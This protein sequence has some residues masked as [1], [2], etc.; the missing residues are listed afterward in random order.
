MSAL[1]PQIL[2]YHGQDRCRSGLPASVEAEL[3]LDNGH[4]IFSTYQISTRTCELVRFATGRQ[5]HGRKPLTLRDFL[6]CLCSPASGRVILPPTL[7]CFDAVSAEAGGGAL[8]ADSGRGFGERL[9][10][11]GHAAGRHPV[12]GAHHA[13]GSRDRPGAAPGRAP[14]RL[15]G[16]RCASCC[17]AACCCTCTRRAVARL[18]GPI[19]DGV[20]STALEGKAPRPSTGVFQETYLRLGGPERLP[21]TLRRHCGMSAEGDAEVGREVWCRGGGGGGPGPHPLLRPGG[22]PGWGSRHPHLAAFPERLR[23]AGSLARR[24]AASP[25]PQFGCQPGTLPPGSLVRPRA[26]G[27]RLALASCRTEWPRGRAHR[28]H[29]TSCP[30]VSACGRVGV[31]V[32]A[33]GGG[34]GRCSR[35]GAAEVVAVPQ[36]R[37]VA[38]AD[39]SHSV[40]SSRGPAAASTCGWP[41]CGGGAVLCARRG[42]A[43]RASQGEGAGGGAGGGAGAEAEVSDTQKAAGG[44]LI[45]HSLRLTRGR[46]SVGDQVPPLAPPSAPTAVHAA[47]CASSG[48]HGS[49]MHRSRMQAASADQELSHVLISGVQSSNIHKSFDTVQEAVPRLQSGCCSPSSYTTGYALCSRHLACSRAYD[50]VHA[51]DGQ[52][53]MT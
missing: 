53:F 52:H 31:R 21:D 51:V 36:R 33:R 19:G 14:G 25:P 28:L 6:L 23:C 5:G 46:L 38:P 49:P 18:N 26:P 8:P 12:S 17:D 22:R 39:A 4:W 44:E 10:A 43:Q 48:W 32:I 37:R 40:P 34:Q 9:R 15:R 3:V 11:D 47:C 20:R 41:A 29:H 24:F 1:T 30:G 13:G 2:L 16:C 45:V 27:A 35:V 50:H 7:G 42:G